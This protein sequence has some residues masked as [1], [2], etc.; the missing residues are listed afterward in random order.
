LVS[1]DRGVSCVRR[2]DSHIRGG[3]GGKADSPVLTGQDTIKATSALSKP[4]NFLART[5]TSDLGT[6]LQELMADLA[7]T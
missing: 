6:M 2:A 3:Q 1:L 5:A 4:P 7:G